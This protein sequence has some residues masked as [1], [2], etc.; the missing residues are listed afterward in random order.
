MAVSQRSVKPFPQGKHCQFESD[1]SHNEQSKTLTGRVKPPARV[2]RTAVFR[3]QVLGGI[4]G[5][6]N[7]GL[8]VPMAGDIP[9]QGKCGGFD[10]LR[11]HNKVT[12]PL[13]KWKSAKGAGII[14]MRNMLRGFPRAGHVVGS[15][16]NDT[17]KKSSYRFHSAHLRYRASKT[18]MRE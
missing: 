9:L 4:R 14:P 7:T 2:V 12:I 13:Q 5:C 6:S 3:R 1:R 18:D 15:L 11:V 17:L 10:P 8:H 16:P